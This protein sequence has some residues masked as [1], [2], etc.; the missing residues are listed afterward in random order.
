MDK[1][2]KQKILD[3]LRK[4]MQKDE[5]LPLRENANSLVFGEGNPDSNVL[6]IGE[7][8]GY[9]EDKKG[10]PFVGNAGSLLNQLLS[11]IKLER[12]DVFITNVIHYRPPNNR[13]PE[14]EE[15]NAFKPYLDEIINIVDPNII[16]TLGRFSMAKF[17]P[18]VK[19]SNVHGKKYKI[20]WDGKEIIVMPMYH[21]AA[22]LR[23]NAIKENLYNDFQ[24]I[25]RVADEAE[26]LEK[27]IDVDQMQ[28]I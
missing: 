13:D 28:L 11:S 8:P 16:V 20:S 1:S 4:K 9:W 26:E 27:K 15:I 5:N 17:I 21:P 24:E 7:G 2:K 3:R 12:S 23:R 25:K 19:I 14:P 22:G 18:N 6:F 10:E